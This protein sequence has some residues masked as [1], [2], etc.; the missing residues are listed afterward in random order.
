M[1]SVIISKGS[2]NKGSPLGLASRRSRALQY[3]QDCDPHPLIM[4]LRSRRGV[5]SPKVSTP[6]EGH[7]IR[8]RTPQH[9]V[10]RTDDAHAGTAAGASEPCRPL[11]RGG[12]QGLSVM[13]S[14]L[15][16]PAPAAPRLAGRHPAGRLIR[17][18]GRDTKGTRSWAKVV[19]IRP[20]RL[21]PRYFPA[22]CRVPRPRSA[23]APAAE[24]GKPSRR[25]QAPRRPAQM[26]RFPLRCSRGQPPR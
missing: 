15:V 7:G 5:R 3:Y 18:H 4:K 2:R 9:D 16:L 6:I 23:P 8:D 19:V 11:T 22:P 21:Q 26:R 10:K 13:P 24:A 17:H 14:G 12:R 25:T 1:V 20:M